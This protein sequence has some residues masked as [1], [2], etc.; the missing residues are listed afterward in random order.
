MGIYLNNKLITN[1]NYMKNF[2]NNSN[3]GNFRSGNSGSRFAEKKEMHTA[4]CAECGDTCQVPFR[5]RGDKPVY[6]SPC[7]GSQS[8]SNYS[9]PSRETREKQNQTPDSH[10]LIAKIDDLIKKLDEISN[11]LIENQAIKKT[12]KVAEKKEVKTEKPE[13]KKKISVK[14]TVKKKK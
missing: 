11:I 12:K 1:F 4:T 3:R 9:K 14:K 2:K 7:F 10:G 13:K 5:P 6:C 8:E